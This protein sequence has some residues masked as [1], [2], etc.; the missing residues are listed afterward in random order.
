M[1]F[2]D[3]QALRELQ[4]FGQDLLT[5]AAAKGSTTSRV[6]RAALSANHRLT[7]TL[8]IDAVMKRHRLD[9]LVAPTGPP[10]ALIDLVN[11]D[12]GTW[13]V[14]S[15]AT[16]AAVAGYPHISVPMGYYRGLPLGISFFGGAWSE[17][18]LIR[19]AYAYEQATKHRR[20]PRFVRSAEL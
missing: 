12:G 5:M 6:Y 20:P 7:R 14:S 13:A 3:A 18:A 2:N 16:I 19:I 11:G 4:F 9:A 10:P 17:P 1:A 8:G 15:P